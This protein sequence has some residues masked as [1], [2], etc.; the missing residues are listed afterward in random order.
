MLASFLF[1][2]GI[3]KSGYVPGHV[4]LEPLLNRL[5][6]VGIQLAPSKTFDWMSIL[7]YFKV[8]NS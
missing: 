1:G 7:S 8:P 4:M 3:A 6:S 2:L 5:Y